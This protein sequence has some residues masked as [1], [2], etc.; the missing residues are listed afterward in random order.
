MAAYDLEE[1]EQLSS[2]KAWW[3]Q[4]GNLVTG[5]LMALAVLSVGYQ[6]WNWYQA[7]QAAKAS[8]VLGVV[9]KAVANKDA[10]RA[11]EATGELLDKFGGTTQAGF[12]ALLS[13]RL[14]LDAGDTKSAK[15]QLSWAAEQ[16]KEEEVRDLARLRLAAVLVDE[17]S[18]DE[19]L[20]Y[21]G[22][23]LG[24]S[25][26]PLFAEARGDILVLQGKKSEARS[27][28]Q[29]ALDK[30]VPAEGADANE[31]RR[32]NAAKDLLTVKLESLGAEK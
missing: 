5:G 25:F 28:Y 4:Y 31:V 11:R 27:A 30:R 22:K 3:Q 26:E 7:N 6:G 14:Q 20:K 16:A 32:D 17:K 21:L 18:Y 23:A 9:E 24:T 29:A 8:A 12:A 2:M 1:Q 10:L 13:A 15:A 19:A